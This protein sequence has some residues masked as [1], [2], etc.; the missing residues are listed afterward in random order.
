[1]KRFSALWGNV[2]KQE[3][4][5][6]SLTSTQSRIP[7]Y[8]ELSKTDPRLIEKI[9]NLLN[10]YEGEVIFVEGESSAGMYISGRRS[11]S[12]A[13][14]GRKVRNLAKGYSGT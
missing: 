7:V 1:M 14:G 8:T 3:T 13:G 9:V 10:Y 12:A 6:G 2:F 11:K 4:D 5:Q